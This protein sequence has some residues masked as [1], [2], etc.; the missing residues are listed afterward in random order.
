[1]HPAR[2]ALLDL[3]AEL[4]AELAELQLSCNACGK[5]CDFSTHENI[6]Y[7]SKLERE[8][9][10]LAGGASCD[11]RDDVCPYLRDEKC[12]AREERT[13]GCRTHFCDAQASEKG[14]GLYEKYRKLIAAICREHNIEWDYRP[15]ME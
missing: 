5:C 9:L 14:R 7:A 11:A 6:L 15:V 3:Y 12:V 4:D 2:R 10:R 8:V 13:L 1:M